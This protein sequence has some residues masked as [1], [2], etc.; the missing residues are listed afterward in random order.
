MTKPAK[1]TETYEVLDALPTKFSVVTP[2]PKPT[3][4]VTLKSLRHVRIELCNVYNAVKQ[5]R[6]D[7]QE[8]SRRTYILGQI[9]KVIEVA[10]LERRLDQLE[11]KKT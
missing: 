1:T 2:L 5:G 10:E 3:R 8:G 4:G 9:G 11:G 6:M 7:S